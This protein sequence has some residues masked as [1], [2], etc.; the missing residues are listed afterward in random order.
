[1]TV[2]L[3]RPGGRAGNGC[4]GQDRE[5]GAGSAKGSRVAR[6]VLQ[7]CGLLQPHEPRMQLAGRAGGRAGRQHRMGPVSSQGGV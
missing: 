7:A 3:G 2:A 6:G 1:M 5:R 4:S